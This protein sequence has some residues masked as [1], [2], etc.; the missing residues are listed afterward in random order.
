[1]LNWLQHKMNQ[2]EMTWL[3]PANQPTNQSDE[4]WQMFSSILNLSCFWVY[5][6]LFFFSM[7]AYLL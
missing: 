1:M 5:L 3:K 4:F 7:G 2:Q 6:L